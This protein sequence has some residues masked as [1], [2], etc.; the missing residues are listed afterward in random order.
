LHTVIWCWYLETHPAGH[1]WT[2]RPWYP[3]KKTPSFLDT[4]AALRRVLWS[5][6]ITAMSSPHADNTKITDAMLDTLAYAA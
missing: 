3:Q 6:R 1:T 5:Q 2:R 4:L